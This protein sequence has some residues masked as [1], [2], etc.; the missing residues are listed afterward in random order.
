MRPT[1]L[2]GIMPGIALIPYWDLPKLVVRVANTV[3]IEGCQLMPG[4]VRSPMPHSTMVLVHLFF[5]YD[6]SGADHICLYEQ[7][8]VFLWSDYQE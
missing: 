2:N 5:C 8:V 1:E 6:I 7:S 3:M 4:E